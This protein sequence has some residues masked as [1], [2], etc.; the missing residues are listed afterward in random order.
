[1]KY[2]RAS[3]A[4]AATFAVFLAALMTGTVAAGQSVPPTQE[5]Q[6]PFPLEA[7]RGTRLRSSTTVPGKETIDNPT[8]RTFKGKWHTSDAC[9]CT[10]Y[11]VGAADP[12]P[13]DPCTSGS[14]TSSVEEQSCWT[15]SGKL[16]LSVKITLINTLLETI[17]SAAISEEVSGC[18][19]HTESRTWPIDRSMCWTSI[20]REVQTEVRSTGTIQEITT[21][22][23]WQGMRDEFGIWVWL[24][25]VGTTT[26]ACAGTSA[27]AW[28]TYGFRL[29]VPPRLC[30]VG[31]GGECPL[32]EP[33][34]EYDNKRR[35][36]CCRPIP[37]CDD[38][39]YP[40]R[41][42]CGCEVPF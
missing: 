37:L 15:S 33:E 2:H 9:D 14:F 26:A 22:E 34:D 35:E 10:Y 39:Q 27:T 12:C 8:Y 17:G 16:E 31:C 24:A 5:C 19:T 38:L 23:W 3:L 30:D 7:P 25:P 18:R 40:Q 11:P 42:C 4:C 6:C 13:P 1:M 29:Q 36:P 21:C 20:V 41:P 28:R 32:P